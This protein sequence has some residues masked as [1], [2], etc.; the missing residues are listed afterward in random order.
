MEAK[1]LGIGN[2]V[3]LIAEGHENQPDTF[4][5][6]IEDYEFYQSKMDFIKPIPL[7]E[8]WVLK[9]RLLYNPEDPGFTPFWYR[10]DFKIHKRLDGFIYNQTK[11]YYV[12]QL[13]NLYFALTGEELE[14][15]PIPQT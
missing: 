10:E 12:H 14:I 8:E 4:K 3:N 5:W 13:Q 15:T 1:E 2:Y 7:T 6:D 9:F 11:I